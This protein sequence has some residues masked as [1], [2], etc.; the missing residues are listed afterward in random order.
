MNVFS[1]KLRIFFSKYI[2]ILIKK[3]V[4]EPVNSIKFIF[5]KC[6]GMGFSLKHYKYFFT[7]YTKSKHANRIIYDRNIRNKFNY[8]FCKRVNDYPLQY[9]LGEWFFKDFIVKCKSPVLIPRI[10][11]EQIV[12][13][14]KNNLRN[15]T[16]KNKNK[17]L[18]FLEIG[19][20][21]GVIFIS[22]LRQLKNIRCIGIDIDERC[23]DLSLTNTK[24]LLSENKSFDIDK[25]NIKKENKDY[26]LINISF[27][28]FLLHPESYQLFLNTNSKIELND[29][30]F[31]FIVS[32]PPYIKF[33]DTQVMKD[34][35]K[36]ESHQA[37]F[38]GTEGL[39]LITLIIQ[40]SRRLVKK[41]GFVI[42]EIDPDQQDT[43][44][45]LLIKEKFSYFLF[46]PD[47]FN[48]IRFLIYYIN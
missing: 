9:I 12:Y 8:Y 5:L 34:V 38:S 47:L 18:N 32:N 17:K 46:E 39:D 42:L 40:N 25:K 11:T 20:G 45:S 7:Y 3:N 21:T 23:I 30:K 37:L 2:S 6:S 14:V 13:L 35:F 19:V 16:Q 28:D 41:G 36:Y 1:I 24:N 15:Y 26:K 29:N 10:E 33:S 31:D 4:S 48:R 44:F 43:L 27:T 22:I